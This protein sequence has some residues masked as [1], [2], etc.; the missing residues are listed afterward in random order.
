MSFYEKL[1]NKILLGQSDANIEFT[2][3]CK[4]LEKLGF[5]MHITGSHHVFRK[6]GVRELINVQKDGGKAKP[7]QIPGQ[8]NFS[9][10]QFQGVVMNK[11]EIIIFYSNEDEAF[12]AE[13]PELPGCMAHGATNEEALRSANDA[14]AAWLET[15]KKFGD[16]IPQPKGRKLMF[17]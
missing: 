3:L 2:E 17:A 9:R 7:C 16:P 13:V 15:A 8:A 1:L 10:L 11:Y 4:L 5:S 14:I 12:I 6:E